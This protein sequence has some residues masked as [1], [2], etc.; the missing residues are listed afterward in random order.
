MKTMP[1]SDLS[2]E[3]VKHVETTRF[4]EIT[5]SCTNRNVKREQAEP[6][7]ACVYIQLHQRNFPG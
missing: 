7:Y 6:D 2:K 3:K 5:N 1:I 4:E